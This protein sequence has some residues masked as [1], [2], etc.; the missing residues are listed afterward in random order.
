MTH[1]K[2]DFIING[3]RVGNYTGD[4]NHNGVAHGDGIGT[5]NNGDTY[6]GT[7]FNGKMAGY[8]TVKFTN[9]GGGHGEIRDGK[10][11]PSFKS[12]LSFQEIGKN[13]TK[14]MK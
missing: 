7:F 14:T 10:E 8:F 5:R 2:A 1:G 12:Y 4:I 13:V 9:G 11:Y 6:Q 3:K